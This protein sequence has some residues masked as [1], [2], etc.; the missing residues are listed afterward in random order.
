MLGRGAGEAEEVSDGREEATVVF[1]DGVVSPF[2]R[3]LGGGYV[4]V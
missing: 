2:E 3:V 4:D 1:P